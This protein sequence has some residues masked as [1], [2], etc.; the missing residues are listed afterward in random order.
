M[1]MWKY[2][3]HYGIDHSEVRL[4]EQFTQAEENYMASPTKPISGYA[5]NPTIHHRQNWQFDP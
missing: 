2:L 5:S 1:D 4:V 3:E